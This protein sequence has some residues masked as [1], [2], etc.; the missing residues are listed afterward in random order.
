[1][2]DITAKEFKIKIKN[3]IIN[4]MR[5]NS[6]KY[7]ITGIEAPLENVWKTSSGDWRNAN[8]FE[9]ISFYRTNPAYIQDV[10]VGTIVNK[11]W[12]FEIFSAARNGTLMK[13][14]ER[15]TK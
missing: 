3:I 12:L 1:M 14:E 10:I 7:V 4:V 5:K 15:T 2:V 9:A 6:K 13:K 11:K 8:G